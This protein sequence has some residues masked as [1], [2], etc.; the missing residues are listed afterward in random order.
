RRLGIERVEYRLDQ[1]KIG[2]TI[3][4]PTHLLTLGDAQLIESDGTESR[5]G[6]VG[7]NR[8][9]SVCRADR[10]GHK[11]PAAVFGFGLR[12]GLPRKRCA[13]LSELVRGAF[14]AAR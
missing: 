13:R 9:L 12:R 8:R 4:Q 11:A 2:A 7:R 5:I 10:A 3:D 6:S 1:Q 14:E